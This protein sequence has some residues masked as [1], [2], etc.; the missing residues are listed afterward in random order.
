MH[1]FF[2]SAGILLLVSSLVGCP[3]FSGERV[4]SNSSSEGTL[5]V[6][7]DFLSQGVAVGDVSSQSALLWL[8]TD[9]PALVQIEWATVSTMGAGLETRDGRGS[10]VENGLHHDDCGDRLYV[11][12]STRRSEPCHA[13]SVS[14]PGRLCWPGTRGSSLRVLWLGVSSPPCRIRTP[15]QR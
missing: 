11:D 5:F 12:Y 2:L 7:S 1:V 6:G 14:C 8:R 10:G 13:L 15:L 3:A 4:R 9:G